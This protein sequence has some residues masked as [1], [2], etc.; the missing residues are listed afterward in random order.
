MSKRKTPCY[1]ACSVNY[2]E[3]DTYGPVV[4][5]CATRKEARKQIDKL[6]A[7]NKDT[8]FARVF[9]RSELRRFSDK[10]LKQMISEYKERL[11]NE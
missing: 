7:D 8:V 5:P 2:W 10:Q 1:Y 11:L 6:V 3:A 9:T 4:G